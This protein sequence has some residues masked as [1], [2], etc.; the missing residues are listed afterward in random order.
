MKTLPVGLCLLLAS[1][2]SPLP[3]LCAQVRESPTFWRD[4]APVFQKHCTICHSLKNID[5]KEIG[6]GLAVSTFE[7]VMKVPMMVTPGKPSES[8]LLDR[9]TTKDDEKRMP[10]DAEPLPPGL[11]EVVRRWIA[12]G[13]PEGEPPNQPNEPAAGPARKQ[14]ASIVR[15]RDMVIKSTTT[16]TNADAR[17]ID[18]AANEGRLDM[19][20][21]L[22]PLPPVAALAYSPDGKL[23]AAAR[24]GSVA[25]W[26]LAEARVA[27]S[28]EFPGAVHSIAFS[29]DG[30]VL[31]VAGGLAARSGLVTLFDT[32]TWRATATLAEHADVVYDVAFSSNGQKLATASLDKTTRVWNPRDLKS[33]IS[34]LKPQVSKSSVTLKGHADS[35]YSAAFTSD[36]KRLVTCSKDRSIKV[37]NVETWELERTLTGHNEDVL[38]VAISPDSTQ[39]VSAGKEPQLR[40][41]T[42]Q[43]GQ[44][45]RRMAGHK[46]SVS[47]LVFSRD[48]KRVASV[49]QDGSVRIWDGS[50]GEQTREIAGSA[51]WLYA[52]AF[53]PDGRFIAAAG[54]DGLVRVWEAE[55]ARPLATLITAPS[56]DP[57]KPQWIALAAE[58][59]YDASDEL[60]D[61]VRWRIDGKGVAGDKLTPLLRRPEVVRKSFQGEPT[62]PVKAPS[63]Q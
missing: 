57:G 8:R 58:G 12:G 39:L 24:Y 55:S 53:N 22:G 62:E 40:W 7:A 56:P 49:G 16:L 54:W 18:P 51:E 29:S 5:K 37:Y 14:P 31:A 30:T 36:G 47:A 11:I 38:A 15:T 23:L 52:V 21:K 48:G 42:L 1:A 28:L 63:L 17:A 25:V 20:V 44:D 41:W 45:V 46:G 2:G 3:L 43:D 4:V 35:V 13:A 33:E 59:Y 61:L 9:L 27:R 26:N 6:G 50:T 19:T 32:A 34:N 60:A 10:L